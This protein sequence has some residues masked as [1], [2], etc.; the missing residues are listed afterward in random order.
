MRMLSG[1]Q[2]SGTTLL[3]TVRIRGAYPS[4]ASFLQRFSG[5]RSERR[6]ALT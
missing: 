4:S 5:E 6:H 3:P 1:L 2:S